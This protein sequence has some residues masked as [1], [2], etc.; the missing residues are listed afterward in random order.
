MVS[1][2]PITNPLGFRSKSLFHTYIIKTREREATTRSS[3]PSF[4]SSFIFS[5]LYSRSLSRRSPIQCFKDRARPPGRII[6]PTT[7][8]RYCARETRRVKARARAI[9]YARA[10]ST[11]RHHRRFVF[12]HFEALYLRDLHLARCWK[13]PAVCL[14]FEL[15]NTW[16]NSNARSVCYKYLKTSWKE[17]WIDKRKCL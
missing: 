11:F 10:C 4:S 12:S 2:P 14:T 13:W 15:A 5:P 7:V 9:P 3:Y 16:G 8:S 17:S 6:K 1:L